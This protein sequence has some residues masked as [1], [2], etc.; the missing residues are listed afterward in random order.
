MYART[1]LDQAHSVFWNLIRANLH[2]AGHDC[3]DTLSQQADEFS[4]WRDPALILSQTCGMPYRIELAGCVSLIGTPDYQLESCSPGYYRSAFVVRADDTRSELTDFRQAR[5]A[6]N[7]PQSQSGFAAAY[8]H[9]IKT[10]FWFQDLLE[11]G[12]HAAS[13]LAVAEHRADI[14]CLDAMTLQL[15]Q[16]YDRY[17]DDLRIIAWTDQSPGLPYICAGSIDPA[18]IAC[19]VRAAIVALP[20]QE[21]QQLGIHALVDIPEAD[22]LCVKNPP[23]KRLGLMEG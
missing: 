23:L 21:Q 1:E 6:Y 16:R 17:S 20:S 11:T 3:P 12:A 5:F 22:Y 10:G 9:A 14:A 8:W 15:I 18:P 4:V 19:A 13:A 2:K 7:A